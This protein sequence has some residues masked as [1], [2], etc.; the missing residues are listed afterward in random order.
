[1][2]WV[3]GVVTAILMMVFIGIVIWAWRD[4]RITGFEEAARLP[5]KEDKDPGA[6]R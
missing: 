6:R 2:G 4:E 3:Y 1:M 5:L